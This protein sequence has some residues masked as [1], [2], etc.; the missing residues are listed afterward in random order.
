M[1]RTTHPRESVLAAFYKQV[2]ILAYIAP[3]NSDTFYVDVGT[4][5]CY[6]ARVLGTLSKQEGVV[7]S[8]ETALEAFYEQV[9]S[10][11]HATPHNSLLFHMDT[12]ALVRRFTQTSD[13][14]SL[15]A[16]GKHRDD[17]LLGAAPTAAQRLHVLYAL[18]V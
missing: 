11:V 5:V 1:H 9:R 17:I 13:T 10:L 12:Y 7:N 2:C 8:R 4:V 3:Y 16:S 18:H 14:Q 6:Y 15:R